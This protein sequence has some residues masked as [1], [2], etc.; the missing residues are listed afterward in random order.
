MNAFHVCGGILAAWALLVSFLGIT[1]ENFP[2]TDGAA[3]IV[4]AISV[5]LV[6]TAISTGIYTAATEEEEGEEGGHEEAALV[7]RI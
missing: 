1:R 4:G 6:V 5:I 7:S 2:A 3:R